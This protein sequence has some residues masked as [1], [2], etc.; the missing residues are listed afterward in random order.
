MLHYVTTVSHVIRTR[1]VIRFIG[2]ARNLC[3]GADNRDA[4]GD[5]GEGNEEGVSPSPAD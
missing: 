2:V 5:E 4:E 1:N 3:W